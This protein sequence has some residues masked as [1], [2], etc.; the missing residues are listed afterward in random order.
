MEKRKLKILEV[1]RPLK[2]KEHS[3][4]DIF[5]VYSKKG[6]DI[7]IFPWKK[8]KPRVEAVVFNHSIF[9]ELRELF[10]LPY[11]EEED[12]MFYDFDLEDVDEETFYDILDRNY[13]IEVF[14]L[15]EIEEK[16]A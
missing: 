7:I 13:E 8:D 15:T 16:R 14:Y 3:V 10:Y 9:R 4:R 5:N 11:W 2:S 12:K 6:Y 1:N